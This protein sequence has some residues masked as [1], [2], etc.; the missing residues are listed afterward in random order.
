MS[1][2]YV[3]KRYYVHLAAAEKMFQIISAFP[4]PE[5]WRSPR[6]K[7]SLHQGGAALD[8]EGERGQLYRVDQSCDLARWTAWTNFTASDAST[9]LNIPPPAPGAASAFRALALP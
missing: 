4:A 2:V 7:A 5:I 9:V 6:L 8:L 3:T 1:V